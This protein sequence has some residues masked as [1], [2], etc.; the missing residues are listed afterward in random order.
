MNRSPGDAPVEVEARLRVDLLRPDSLGLAPCPVVAQAYHSIEACIW[1][2]WHLL[3]THCAV[4]EEEGAK[5]QDEGLK[6]RRLCDAFTSTSEGM[7]RDEL[8]SVCG[9]RLSMH[10]RRCNRRLS[11]RLR[12]LGRASSLEG[13]GTSLGKYELTYWRYNMSL[14]N[15][16]TCLSLGMLQIA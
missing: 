6:D 15:L 9:R 16:L 11:M 13:F 12:R 14:A 8:G 2:Y 5:V 10:L 7:D 3:G 1:R 4:A